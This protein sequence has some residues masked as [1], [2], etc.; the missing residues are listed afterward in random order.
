[1]LFPIP[2]NPPILHSNG[3]VYEAVYDFVSL[4]S[5]M[6]VSGESIIRAWQNRAHP[7]SK[8]KDFFILTAVSHERRGSNVEVYGTDSLMSYELVLCRMQLDCYSAKPETARARAQ[9]L[10]HAARSSVGMRFFRQRGI[11]FAGVSNARDLTGVDDSQQFLPRWV[12]ELVLS[13]NSVI[14]YEQ[15]T[16]DNVIVTLENVDAHHTP[17][18]KDSGTWHHMKQR[19]KE[20]ETE[21]DSESEQETEN[22]HEEVI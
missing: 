1:M 9:S 6:P 14:E 11:G 2:Q 12:V 22:E 20:A 4:F 18:A 15:P 19:E 8:D 7:P 5:V 21:N 13:Y 16:F 3:D 10:E 17:P